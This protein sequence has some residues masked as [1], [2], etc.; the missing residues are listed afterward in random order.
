MKFDPK[1]SR[2]PDPDENRGPRIIKRRPFD[3]ATFP[4]WGPKVG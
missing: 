4:G 2:L 3:A 1:P